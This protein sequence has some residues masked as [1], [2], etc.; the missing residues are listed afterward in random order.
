MFKNLTANELAALTMLLVALA[1]CLIY[2]AR[3]VPSNDWILVTEDS[4]GNWQTM[5][6]NLTYSDCDK[7]AELV[8]PHFDVVYCQVNK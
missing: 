1:I 2:I 3:P 7:A 8:K 5:D 6:F 4:N